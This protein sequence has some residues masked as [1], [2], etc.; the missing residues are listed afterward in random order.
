MMRRVFRQLSPQWLRGLYRKM[1]HLA[2][3]PGDWLCCRL[4]G[5]AWRPDW[6]LRGWVYF[7]RSLGGR[8]SGGCRFIANSNSRDNAIGVFQPV[9]LTAIGA[10]SVIQIGDDVGVSGCSITAAQRVAIGNRVLIGSGVLITDN[11]GHPIHPDGRRY[12]TEYASAPI[13]IGDDVFIGARAII[14]KGVHVGQGAIVGA[15][16]VVTKDVPPYAIVAGNPA[17]VVG[18]AR[19]APRSGEHR[20]PSVSVDVGNSSR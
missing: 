8:I 13:E 19:N 4:Q 5:V 14:L 9:I 10:D 3:V 17:R 7:R 1:R 6:S 18:D 15:G 20:E 12:G 2:G 11:D 16:A